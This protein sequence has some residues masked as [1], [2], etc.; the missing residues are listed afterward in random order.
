[1]VIAYTLFTKDNEMSELNELGTLTDEEIVIFNQCRNNANQIL[2]QIGQ[3]EARKSRL[4]EELELNE[5][6]AQELLAQVRDRYNL[7]EDQN[8][9]IQSDGKILSDQN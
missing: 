8:W 7:S 5:G 6:N 9:R 4:V 1:M 2:L 3:L